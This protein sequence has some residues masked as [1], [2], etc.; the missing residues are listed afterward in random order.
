L[1]K[2][3]TVLC[4]ALQFQYTQTSASN[5]HC[6]IANHQ[7]ED[8]QV[9]LVNTKKQNMHARSTLK[10]KAHFL[11]LPELKNTFESQERE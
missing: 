7:I 3:V 6:I 4:E 5:A 10:V 9:Q 2:C 8:P 11:T 1:H